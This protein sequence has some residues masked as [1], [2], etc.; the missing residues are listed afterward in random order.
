MGCALSSRNPIRDSHALWRVAEDAPPYATKANAVHQQGEVLRLA[1]SLVEGVRVAASDRKAAIAKLKRL[2]HPSSTQPANEDLG[3]ELMAA[4]R[5]SDR[6]LSE[7]LDL[8]V[9][10]DDTELYL[11]DGC[12]CM[13]QWMDVH[14]GM[15]RVSAYEH[16]RV[17]RALRDLPMCAALFALGKLSY[18]KARI[19]TR[20]ATPATDESFATATLDLSASETERWCEHYR[21]D[22]DAAAMAAAEDAEAQGLLTAFERRALRTRDVDAFSTRITIDLPKDMAAE[23]LR[24]LEHCDDEVTSEVHDRAAEDEI[25][26]RQRRADAAVMMSRRSLAHAGEAVATADRFRVHVTV[27]AATLAAACSGADQTAGPTPKPLMDGKTP[28]PVATVRRLAAQAGYTSYV[29]DDAGN[30]FASRR[31]AA[32]F[33][34][35]QLRALRARDGCCQMP[36]CG[37]TRHLDGHHVVPRAEGGRSTLD[38]A[39]LLCGGCHRLLHEGGFQLKR[40]VATYPTDVVRRYRLFDANG[41]EHGSRGAALKRTTGGAFTRVNALCKHAPPVNGCSSP[42]AGTRQRL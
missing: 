31:E 23:F 12:R 6:Y 33:T 30:P 29:V 39:V 17:G 37:N 8:L 40:T 1:M 27:D 41:R 5:K 14:L 22:Q 24:S 11:R 26:P 21:H 9:R 18:T 32:P 19:I 3:R 7:K 10:F 25:T 28:L 4:A 13:T 38:N 35:R 20:H 42:S 2:C 34:R 36:G 16:L 15:A